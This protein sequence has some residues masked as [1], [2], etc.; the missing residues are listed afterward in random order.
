MLSAVDTVLCSAS[1]WRRLFWRAIESSSNLPASVPGGRSRGTLTPTTS[2]PHSAASNAAWMPRAS[3]STN[4]ASTGGEST[5]SSDRVLITRVTSRM[6][7]ALSARS[8]MSPWSRRERTSF[9]NPRYLGSSPSRT[10]YCST[11]SA[12]TSANWSVA[13]C[14]APVAPRSDPSPPGASETRLTEPPPAERVLAPTR[15]RFVLV[16]TSMFS[17]PHTTTS[18]LVTGV[19]TP[20]GRSRTRFTSLTT[21]S[22]T[23]HG[24]F[25]I[26]PPW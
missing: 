11:M 22:S 25:A 16:L 2:T 18:S 8:R 9:E 17:P 14:S 3:T 21:A 7:I 4:G 13:C 6:A 10:R 24:I 1:I 12:S 19:I 5:S 15:K 26:G 23:G 20:S